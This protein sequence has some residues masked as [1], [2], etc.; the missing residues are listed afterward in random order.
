MSFALFSLFPLYPFSIP[1]LRMAD[2]TGPELWIVT[3]WFIH[4]LSILA[5]V[6]GIAALVV[7]AYKRW[8][9]EHMRSNGIWLI[10]IS[11]V[12]CLFTVVFSPVRPPWRIWFLGK[13][14]FDGDWSRGGMASPA[15][16]MLM[17]WM[18]DRL[19]AHDEKATGKAEEEHEDMREMMRM[20]MQMMGGGRMMRKDAPGSDGNGT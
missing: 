10:V 9:P 18:T 17:Q 7:W 13:G 2:T 16:P 6:L 14:G 20:M 8:S 11:V 1:M 15:A 5:F 4:F 3:L 12:L 19:D